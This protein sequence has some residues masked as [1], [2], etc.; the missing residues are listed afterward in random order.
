MEVAQ[1]NEN[2]DYWE[3]DIHGGEKKDSS[4]LKERGME[5]ECGISNMTTCTIT[6]WIILIC[7]THTHLSQSLVEIL[8]LSK[9][10]FLLGLCKPSSVQASAMFGYFSKY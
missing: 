6:V 5:G 1:R 10:S 2:A 8:N 4:W 3:N 7:Y 9:S